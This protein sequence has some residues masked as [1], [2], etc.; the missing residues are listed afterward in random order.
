MTT[1]CSIYTDVTDRTGDTITLRAALEGIRDGRWA[2]PVQTYRD[3]IAASEPAAKVEAWKRSLPGVTFAGTFSQRS[4]TTCTGRTGCLVLD[5]DH[6]EQPAA[7]RESVQASPHVLAAFLSVSGM[8]L[9]VVVA[10]DLLSPHGDCFRAAERH[11]RETFG[12]EADAS[13]KDICRLCFVSLDPDAFIR[14]RAEP[15]DGEEAPEE[16]TPEAKPHRPQAAPLA[17]GVLTPGDDYDR[18]GDFP[19]LLQSH[20][21]KP[22]GRNNWT[23]PGKASGISATFGNVRG[24]DGGPRFFIFSTSV[25]TLRA[26]HTYKPWQVYA[27]L[28]YGGDYGAAAS[29]LRRAGFG[30]ERPKPAPPPPVEVSHDEP[31]FADGTEEGQEEPVFADG[32]EDAPAAPPKPALM[33]IEIPPIRTIEEDDELEIEAPVPLVHGLIHRG[34]VANL[35]GPSK[36]RKT[37]GLMH[38]G[39]SVA[40]GVPWLGW[41]CEQAPVLYLDLELMPY[42]FRERRREIHKAVQ[43]GVD[44]VTMRRLP[45]FSWSLRG[46]CPQLKDLREQMVTVC[47]SEGIGMVIV[48]PFYMIATGDENDADDMREAMRGF[49]SLALETGAAIVYAHHYSKGNQSEKNAMD[50]AA[51]SGV[52][53]RGCDTLMAMTPHKEDEHMVFE[54]VA[55]GFPPP[56]AHVLRWSHPVWERAPDMDPKE[57][58]KPG[59]YAKKDRI[60]KPDT[61]RKEEAPKKGQVPA[62]ELAKVPPEEFAEAIEDTGKV[63]TRN[64]SLFTERFDVPSRAIWARWR[65]WKASKD[66]QGTIAK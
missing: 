42:H 13:G 54:A 43:P 3:M 26:N 14:D 38:L 28:E 39:L 15:L 59:G 45:F 32:T 5:F 17:D 64:M 61:A 23:R 40:S 62:A 57:L 63:S 48:D 46:V 12:L 30:G 25:D 10:V 34:G 51:G 37:W 60:E 24:S 55:R 7:A 35:S 36:S 19:A 16:A 41:Q 9:K 18:R 27:E 2:E 20:G 56:G 53:A 4:K 33:R 29:A 8:G 66:A 52:H 50:R 44:P 11:M 1:L 58:A 6:L 22:A 21:W 49:Q 31:V 47:R 65:E